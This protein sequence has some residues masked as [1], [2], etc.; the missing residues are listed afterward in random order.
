MFIRLKNF[1]PKLM[2]LVVGFTH[3]IIVSAQVSSDDSP[4]STQ[5][6]PFS[7]P[8]FYK[9]LLIDR[10]IGLSTGFNSQIAD[11]MGLSVDYLRAYIDQKPDPPV[12]QTLYQNFLLLGSAYDNNGILL[13]PDGEPRFRMVWVMGGNAA[14]HGISL[15]PNG[16]AR[17]RSFF[18]NGG[19][20]S[21]SCAGA[22]LA[23]YNSTNFFQLWYG[24][25]WPSG[26][27][28]GQPT[29]NHD[30]RVTTDSPLINLP[31]FNFSP[32][33]VLGPLRHIGGGYLIEIPQGTEILLTYKNLSQTSI[34][35][36]EGEPVC[37]AY[38]TNADSGRLV[39]I[40]S[41]TE[42]GH[43]SDAIEISKAMI[44]Y[45]LAGQGEP[46]LKAN[47]DNGIPWCMNRLTED[48]DPA[49][50]RIGDRQYHHFKV[51][52]TETSQIQIDLEEEA[53]WNSED[54]DLHVYVRQNEFAYAN[55]PNLLAS[56]SSDGLTKSLETGELPLGI[57]YIGVTC[58]NTVN[59]SHNVESPYEGSVAVLNGVAYRIRVTW[60]DQQPGPYIQNLAAYY[61]NNAPDFSLIGWPE[62]GVFRGSGVNGT[63]FS[64][65]S[66]APG[67]Y[68]I[69]YTLDCTTASYEVQIYDFR[70]PAVPQGLRVV[71]SKVNPCLLGG[72]GVGLFVNP[73][74]GG[75]TY[76]WEVADIQSGYFDCTQANSAKFV[77]YP[78][79]ASAKV[80]VS[81]INEFGQGPPTPWLEIFK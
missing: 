4:S 5:D 3:T 51:M 40:G 62:R 36:I 9:D 11:E 52:L 69:T 50:T 27:E 70:Q 32:F 44:S 66:M 46:E 74:G 31:G 8:G 56:D 20:Y 1:S 23:D 47:L 79:F 24:Y 48:A 6:N 15:E 45:A 61:I 30:V 64:P 10:G 57:Y 19:S 43:N 33:E 38:K 7:T 49:H 75:V 81:A 53:G 72:N 58:P 76:Q 67:T 55:S 18:D 77:F 71:L 73:L 26:H 12:D 29:V 54:F 16:Q 78:S 63:L 80:R 21:G 42:Q 60:G 68:T 39:N 2:L 35:P 13:F 28:L 25:Q 34:F 22:F 65:S 59:F 41:H 37:W 14:E 17:F